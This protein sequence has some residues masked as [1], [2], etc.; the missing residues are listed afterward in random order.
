M[1]NSHY[2]SPLITSVT[3]IK[4][5]PAPN[6]KQ[7][8]VLIVVGHSDAGPSDIRLTQTAAKE[9]MG[10]LSTHPLVGRSR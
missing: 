8:S 5:V 7:S 2:E 3:G 4:V 1:T 10:V 9:L 6:P